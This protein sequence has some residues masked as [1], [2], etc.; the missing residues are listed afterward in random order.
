MN[1]SFYRMK[2]AVIHNGVYRYNSTKGSITS[3]RSSELS[4]GGSLSALFPVAKDFL[5]HHTPSQLKTATPRVDSESPRRD[6]LR[7]PVRRAGHNNNNALMLFL[8]TTRFVG[9]YEKV[10]CYEPSEEGVKVMTLRRGES[11]TLHA[12]RVWTWVWDN[13]TW[14]WT[15]MWVPGCMSFSSIYPLGNL[16][17]TPPWA[18]REVGGSQGSWARGRVP[19]WIRRDRR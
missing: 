3:F 14:T 15:W 16:V 5:R 13:R 8:P 4:Y 6:D 9:Y 2:C 11:V 12:A 1:I 18:S 10:G 19:G 7:P 17:S